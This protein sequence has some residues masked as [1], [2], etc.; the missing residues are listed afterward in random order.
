M[1]GGA[2]APPTTSRWPGATREVFREPGGVVWDVW[3]APTYDLDLAPKMVLFLVKHFLW[4]TGFD[5]ILK[6]LINFPE[7]QIMI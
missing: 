3:E 1:P 7:P 6:S 5:F 2:A 4:V